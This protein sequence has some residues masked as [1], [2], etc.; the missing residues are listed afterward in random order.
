MLNIVCYGRL[1]WLTSSQSQKTVSYDIYKYVILQYLFIFQF[2]K[3]SNELKLWQFIYNAK[4]HQL[5]NKA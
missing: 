3:S 1:P 5:W 4:L 2:R